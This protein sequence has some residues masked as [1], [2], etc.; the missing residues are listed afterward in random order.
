MARHV[1]SLVSDRR[2]RGRSGLSGPGGGTEGNRRPTTGLNEKMKTILAFKGVCGGLEVLAITPDCY[3]R[4]I[5]YVEDQFRRV[6]E[7]SC[8]SGPDSGFCEMLSKPQ[9]GSVQLNDAWSFLEHRSTWRV[10][11]E[12]SRHGARESWRGDPSTDNDFVSPV[13]SMA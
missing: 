12:N 2:A 9:M 7:D 8:S 5:E 1:G 13:A 10:G 3:R 11:D 4:S 6:T